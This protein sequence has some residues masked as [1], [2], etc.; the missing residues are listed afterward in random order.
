MYSWISDKTFNKNF[1][2]RF[3]EK[4]GQCYWLNNDYVVFTL[5]KKIKISEID[6]TGDQINIIELPQQADKI[7]FSQEDKKLYAQFGKE[8]LVSEQLT[9]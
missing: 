9:Q 8:T 2:N 1:L 4:I 5:G 3:S 7:Y 6:T